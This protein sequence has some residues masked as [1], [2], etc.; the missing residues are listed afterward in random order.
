MRREHDISDGA[1]HW[2][3]DSC[4]SPTART[5]TDST[6]F[7]PH[8]EHAG[9]AGRMGRAAHPLLANDASIVIVIVIVLLQYW[10]KSLLK[11]AVRASQHHSITASLTLSGSS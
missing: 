2:P 5:S 3:A 9:V 8:V 11:S 10:Q 7:L 1:L 4:G 6:R